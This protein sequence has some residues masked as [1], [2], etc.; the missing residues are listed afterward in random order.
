[1]MNNKGIL[2]DSYPA[3]RDYIAAKWAQ[4]EEPVI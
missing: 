1:M 3:E 2:L 4:V